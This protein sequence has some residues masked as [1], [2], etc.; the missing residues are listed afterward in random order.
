MLDSELYEE[1]LRLQSMLNEVQ[2]TDEEDQIGWG[3]TP[4]K[5]FTTKSLY[6]L[7]TDGG[8]TCRL[9]MKLWKCRVPLRIQ[10]FLWQAFQNRLQTGQQL[11]ERN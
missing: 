4:S 6:R 2:L 9:A 7:M 5:C 10:I 8:I 1:W 11:K 3:R